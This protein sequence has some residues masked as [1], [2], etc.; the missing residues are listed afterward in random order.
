MR[1]EQRGA[2][3]EQRA[4]EHHHEDQ[5]CKRGG[6]PAHPSGHRARAGKEQVERNPQHSRVDQE[7]DSE[8]SR[9]TELRYPRVVD[10]ARLHH[11]PA[12][13]TLQ[14]S[15]PEY[16]QKFPRQR[17]AGE[18]PES[19]RALG[20]RASHPRGSCTTSTAA[21][22][23]RPSRRRASASFARSSG[24]VSTE[25]LT[26]T[27]GASARNSSPSRRVRLATETTRRSP[28]RIA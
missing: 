26:G 3:N 25:V 17:A 20:E 13:R 4:R 2:E 8:V 19:D 5:Y 23:M 6:E 12:Q 9:E 27:L 1:G 14:P 16:R 7:G 21:P 28:H 10:Q 22:L 24:K 11:V 15:Q 18:Q